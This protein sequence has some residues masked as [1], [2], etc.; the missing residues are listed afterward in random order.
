MVADLFDE[1]SISFVWPDVLVGL[2]QKRIEGLCDTTDCRCI[3][4]GREGCN[5][6]QALGGINPISS[7]V[8]KISV[9]HILSHTLQ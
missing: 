8:Q 7:C 9:L 4:T 2:T 5:I 6:D 3:L 1:E